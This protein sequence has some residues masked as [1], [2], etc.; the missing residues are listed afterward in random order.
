MESGARTNS[1]AAGLPY[2]R[3]ATMTPDPGKSHESYDFQSTL[4]P[5]SCAREETFSHCQP[6]S[7]SWTRRAYNDDPNIRIRERGGLLQQRQECL[8]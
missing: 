6:L 8:G 5:L 7:Q 4:Y 2:E 1:K 3:N